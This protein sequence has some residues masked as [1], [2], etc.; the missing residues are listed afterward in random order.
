MPNGWSTF[1]DFEKKK[2][3]CKRVVV[4]LNSIPKF[5]VKNELRCTGKIKNL[6]CFQWHKK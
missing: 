6:R 2:V 1:V 3:R 4:S 5:Q